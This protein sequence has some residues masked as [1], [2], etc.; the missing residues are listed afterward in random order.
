MDLTGLRMEGKEL[1]QSSKKIIAK[2]FI[3]YMHLSIGWE[4]V[5]NQQCLMQDGATPH[6][7]TANATLELL[8][9]KFVDRVISQKKTDN[10]CAAQSPDFNPCDF[11]ANLC[12]SKD[13]LKT[14]FVFVFRQYIPLARTSWED[15][16]KMSW[17]RGICSSWSYVLQRCL[18][19]VSKTCWRSLAKMSSRHFQDV[20]K[21]YYQVI[22]WFCLHVFKTY[23]THCWDILQ[24]RLSAERLPRSY[25]K[26]FMVR[27]QIFQW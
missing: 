10:P 6:T 2:S 1:V 15:V 16:L 3:S 11:P 18:E 4:I 25:S 21:I 27:L 13:V 5:I 9:H 12:L 22:N 17:S 23:S 14:S 19:D 26:K 20:F 24:R 8:T 7:H